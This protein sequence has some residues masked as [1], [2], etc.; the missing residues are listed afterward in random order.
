MG[1]S[2]STGKMVGALLVGA[3]IGGT[4]GAALGILFAPEKGSDLRK[5]LLGKGDALTNSLKARF[6][7]F[8]GEVKKETGAPKAVADEFVENGSTKVNKT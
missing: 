5:K 8:T 6:G 2:Y 4:I 7:N 3:A 1:K